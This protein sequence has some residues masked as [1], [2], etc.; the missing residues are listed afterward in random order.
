MNK[1]SGL[2]IAALLL[3]I[4]MPLQAEQSFILINGYEK[5]LALYQNGWKINIAD[6]FKSFDIDLYLLNINQFTKENKFLSSYFTYAGIARDIDLGTKDYLKFELVL[7][8]EDNY[9]PLLSSSKIMLRE[10]FYHIININ[11]YLK[12]QLFQQYADFTNTDILDF[13]RLG[14][15]GKVLKRASA[16]DSIFSSAQILYTYL[17][18]WRGSVD[19]AGEKRHDFTGTVFVSFSR[20]LSRNFILDMKYQMIF[21]TSS[22]KAGQIDIKYYQLELPGDEDAP[23]V[24]YDYYDYFLHALSFEFVRYLSSRFFVKILFKFESKEYSERKAYREDGT[25]K[26]ELERDF[27][28]ISSL[29]FILKDIPVKHINA[30]IE[31]KYENKSS[32]NEFEGYFYYNVRKLYLNLNLLYN[33]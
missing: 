32:N 14:L 26:S 15:F 4:L 31:L 27:N 24:A 22:S 7:K 19:E 1:T 6:E 17:P 12:F 33:F 9:D 23:A 5:T 18:K 20:Y 21:N 2:L 11:N 29:L 25:L 3:F 8:N 30:F 16:A 13:Y 28:M 10:N